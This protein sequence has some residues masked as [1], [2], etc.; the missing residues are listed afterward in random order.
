MSTLRV[1]PTRASCTGFPASCQLMT[2]EHRIP[3]VIGLKGGSVTCQ[4]AEVALAQGIKQVEQ[5]RVSAVEAA[6][7]PPHSV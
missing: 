6:P 5:L 2:G 7:K 4:Y 3:E 1:T